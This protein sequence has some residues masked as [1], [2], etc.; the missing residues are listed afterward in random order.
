MRHGVAGNRLS[1][2]R[3]LRKATLRDLAKATL[4]HQRVCT[5]FAKAKEARKLVEQLITLGKKG[6]LAHRRRA[7]AILCDHQLVSELFTKISPR[8][9]SR[10]GGYTRLIPI[11]IRR[12]DSAQMT[13]LEL[14]EKDKIIIS[15][16]KAEKKVKAK[17]TA[18]ST[19][20]DAEKPAI[21]EQK[22]QIE[23]AKPAAP[24]GHHED[25]SGGKIKGGT[26][27][28]L[29]SGIKNIFRKKPSAE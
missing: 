8:F 12:G 18:P 6:Q 24:H 15:N 7:F 26:G 14:T 21:Q 27:K 19:K 16:I 11:G 22:Q 5:T 4:I 1:R 2:N 10:V 25:K 3:S 23:K 28:N 29:A 20:Q 13:Y 17:E 9:Q